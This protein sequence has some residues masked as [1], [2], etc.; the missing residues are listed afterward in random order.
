[1][2]PVSFSQSQAFDMTPRFPNIQSAVEDSYA[3]ER[4]NGFLCLAAMR[5]STTFFAMQ[6]LAATGGLAQLKD[7]PPWLVAELYQWM[8]VYAEK[9]RLCFLSNLGEVDHSALAKRLL[10]I[11]P[12]KESFGPSINLQV[13]EL[14]HPSGRVQRHFTYYVFPQDGFHILHG[15]HREYSETGVLE[16]TEFRHGAALSHS[17]TFGA[18]GHE[19]RGSSAA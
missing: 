10:E 4:T 13:A 14:H 11:L 12:P 5:S 8:D 18:T 19:A 6:R 2:P 1:M 15:L 16:E 7:C 17:R 9:G 3:M